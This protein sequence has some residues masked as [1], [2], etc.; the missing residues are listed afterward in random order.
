[1]ALAMEETFVK[2]Q[3]KV[4]LK[5]MLICFPV[6][7]PLSLHLVSMDTFLRRASESAADESWFTGS[8]ESR[9]EGVEEISENVAREHCNRQMIVE[10]H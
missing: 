7:F 6:C 10:A 2:V 4:D 3:R 5:S 1:M 8:C 9:H